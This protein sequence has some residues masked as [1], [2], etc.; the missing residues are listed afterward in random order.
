[1]SVVGLARTFAFHRS[2]GTRFCIQSRGAT[3]IALVLGVTVE[4]CGTI[5][6]VRGIGVTK[7]ARQA[8]ELERLIRE[9][10]L[11]ETLAETFP[12]SDPLSTLPNP[13]DESVLDLRSSEPEPV[14]SDSEGRLSRSVM[15]E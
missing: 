6:Q 1:M 7:V 9:A 15:I 3:L 13:R 4:R 2:S 5:F 11:D 10:A 14:E 12:A 8:P